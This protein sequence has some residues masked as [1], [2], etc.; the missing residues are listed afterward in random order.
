MILQVSLFAAIS[1]FS[2]LSLQLCTL[3]WAG[4]FL[5]FYL[6]PETLGKPWPFLDL[7]KYRTAGALLRGRR[8]W[9][10]KLPRIADCVTYKVPDAFREEAGGLPLVLL[11]LHL[12]GFG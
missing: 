10:F 4:V 8:A 5:Y 12:C 2:D 7:P 9:E 11:L 3:L 1:A 6:M